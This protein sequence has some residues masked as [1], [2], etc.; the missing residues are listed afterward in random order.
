MTTPVQ[1]GK[2]T[3]PSA[4]PGASVGGQLHAVVHVTLDGTAG[5]ID[6]DYA[7]IVAASYTAGSVTIT[8]D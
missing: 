1:H 8:M 4:R 7:A 2:Q 6:A 5:Q 3:K